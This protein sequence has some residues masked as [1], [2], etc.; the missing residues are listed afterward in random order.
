[1][2]RLEQEIMRGFG[3]VP[4][5]Q[6]EPAPLG[7]AVTIAHRGGRQVAL[8][9]PSPASAGYAVERTNFDNWRGV[10]SPLGGTSCSPW[11]YSPRYGEAALKPEYRRPKAWGGSVPW[12]QVPRDMSQHQWKKGGR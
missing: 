9:M 8:A 11:G 2:N 3:F 6:A 12:Q 10:V 4:K 7:R 1:M 5:A